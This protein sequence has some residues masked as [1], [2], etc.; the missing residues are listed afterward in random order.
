MDLLWKEGGAM[1]A[2]GRFRKAIA[3][4][5]EVK[6]SEQ[7]IVVPEG[8]QLAAGEASEGLDPEGYFLY[9]PLAAAVQWLL[10]K[11]HECDPDF[12]RATATQ[13]RSATDRWI[14]MQPVIRSHLNTA[15]HLR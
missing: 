11:I 13:R 7:K 2:G 10:N 4:D 3:Y 1:R 9:H 5:R 6:M 15:C 14:R 8:M 12:G